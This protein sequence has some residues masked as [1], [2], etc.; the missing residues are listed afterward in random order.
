MS[1][2]KD[3][4]FR[5]PIASQICYR[6]FVIVRLYGYSLQSRMYYGISGFIPLNG[7]TLRATILERNIENSSDG[8]EFAIFFFFF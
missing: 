8:T 2:F 3:L 7:E 4:S 6:S 5:L 1:V